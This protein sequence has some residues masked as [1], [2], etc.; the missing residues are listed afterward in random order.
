MDELKLIKKKLQQHGY[1]FISLIRFGRDVN[2]REYTDIATLFQ[3]QSHLQVV[4][5]YDG[6]LHDGYYECVLCFNNGFLECSI[7]DNIIHVKRT[8]TD[9]QRWYTQYKYLRGY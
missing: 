8:P 2:E 6:Q 1:T 7:N 5:L 4:A 9:T 3:L